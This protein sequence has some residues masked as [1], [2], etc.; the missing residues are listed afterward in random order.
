[1]C[2]HRGSDAGKVSVVPP[3]S[4]RNYANELNFRKDVDEFLASP[5]FENR[6]TGFPFEFATSHE[7]LPASRPESNDYFVHDEL[8]NQFDFLMQSDDNQ[9]DT[10]TSSD[11]LSDPS[12][13]FNGTA[14]EDV[15][16]GFLPEAFQDTETFNLT[17]DIAA[18]ISSI[19]VQQ[20][21]QET[22]DSFQTSLEEIETLFKDTTM[23]GSDA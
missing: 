3:L 12:I 16:W 22:L 15:S 8:E 14:K 6:K 13:D 19:D 7:V 1:M 4:I 11:G 10:S 9:S 2:P 21:D 18:L 20:M 5:L 23:S 17:P